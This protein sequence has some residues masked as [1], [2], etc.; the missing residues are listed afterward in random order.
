MRFCVT[1]KKKI[2]GVLKYTRFYFI[3][4]VLQSQMSPNKKKRQLQKKTGA[5][6]KTTRAAVAESIKYTEEK[7]CDK[8]EDLLLS[9]L[10]WVFCK[11][12]SRFFCKK[13]SFL[14]ILSLR[15]FYFLRLKE[16]SREKIH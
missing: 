9:L 11:L 10:L 13:K 5:Q 1:P 4:I 3:L 7:C 14:L 8:K 6:L 2:K 15:P 12:L 16:P